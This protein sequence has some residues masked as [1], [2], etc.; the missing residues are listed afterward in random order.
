[1]GKAGDREVAKIGA[2]RAGRVLREKP[3]YFNFLCH[4]LI[5]VRLL[6]QDHT[7]GS[8]VL[9]RLFCLKKRYKDVKP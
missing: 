8:T 9:I 1:V 6:S 3:K 5:L 4:H 7:W 2:P